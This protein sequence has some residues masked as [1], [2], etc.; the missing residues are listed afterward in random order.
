MNA[1]TVEDWRRHFVAYEDALA[2]FYSL[3]DATQQAIDQ[4]Q[5]ITSRQAAL[6]RLRVP[7][8]EVSRELRASADDG[9]VAEIERKRAT[10]EIDG[11]AFSVM[12]LAANRSVP[13]DTLLELSFRVDPKS[14]PRFVNLTGPVRIRF[15][16]GDTTYLAACRLVHFKFV[17]HEFSFRFAIVDPC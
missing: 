14:I 9:R 11:V 8:H 2:S 13:D 17:S 16:F 4:S 3:Q 1:R 5:A 12:D 15:P 6:A 10:V 7:I